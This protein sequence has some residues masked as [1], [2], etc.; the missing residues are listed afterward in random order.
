MS[1]VAMLLLGFLSV[2]KIKSQQR[3]EDAHKS[4]HEAATWIE[5]GLLDRGIP[6]EQL[7]KC[8][9]SP[10]FGLK[11]N[12][13]LKTP[14]QE[15]IYREVMAE[16]MHLYPDVLRQAHSFDLKQMHLLDQ[17]WA[18]H[19]GLSE[20][21]EIVWSTPCAECRTNR[22]RLQNLYFTSRAA[23]RRGEL[24]REIHD[25]SFREGPDRTFRGH[26]CD[27]CLQQLGY[28]GMQ[29]RHPPMHLRSPLP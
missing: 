15:T 14:E 18:E 5:R 10:W 19:Y 20:Y 16:V 7:L 21:A 6:W 26:I 25:V 4:G 24:H 9:Y 12:V 13:T 2:E 17:A 29:T 23:E 28:R 1:I 27:P 8:E 22:C 3:F 11:L